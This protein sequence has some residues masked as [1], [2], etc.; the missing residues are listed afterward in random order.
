M[1]TIFM[2]TTITAC[3]GL[4]RR[5]LSLGFRRRGELFN[6]IVFFV[7]VVSLFPLGVGPGPKLLATIAPGVIWVA[8]LLAT[9]LATPRK[10]SRM[11]GRAIPFVLSWAKA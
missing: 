5:D 4:L 8:A 6:P 11:A 10:S 1:A 3:L 9:L 7:L 2:A